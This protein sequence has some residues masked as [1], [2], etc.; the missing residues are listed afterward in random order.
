LGVAV[1]RRAAGEL[2]E[3][4]GIRSTS[5]AALLGD[6][7]RGESLPER[8]VLVVDEAGMVATRQL[9]E[10]LGHVERASGKLGLGGDDRQ[11]P[12]IEAGGAFRGLIQRG[13]AL[14]L[15]ENVR[16]VNLWER[17]AL[18]HLRAGRAEEALDLYA[19]HDSLIVAATGDE[20]RDRLVGDWTRTQD[21]GD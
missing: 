12:A 6:L 9:A 16:Q 11:V 20:V 2:W 19:G 13:L 18:D 8:C 1:A 3:G 15:G 14:E 17:E 7:D 4:A 10:L 5:V 21:G